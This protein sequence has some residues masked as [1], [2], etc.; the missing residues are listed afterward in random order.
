[1][2]RTRVDLGGIMLREINGEEQI[3]YAL[4]YTWNLKHK[5]NS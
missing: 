1:M 2:M 4:T 3:L 5:P